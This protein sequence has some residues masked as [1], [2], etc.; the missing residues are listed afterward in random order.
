MRMTHLRGFCPAVYPMHR[1][2]K[3]VPDRMP[4]CGPRRRLTSLAMHQRMAGPLHH[5]P[6]ECT[7]ATATCGNAIVAAEVVGIALALY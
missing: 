5:A 2:A 1:I 3:R 4:H 7:T 6:Y